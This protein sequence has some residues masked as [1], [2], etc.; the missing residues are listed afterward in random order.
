M[1]DC[2]EQTEIFFIEN[3]QFKFPSGTVPVVGLP[4]K[5][6]YWAKHEDILRADERS[7]G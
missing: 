3:K 2:I 1:T 5:R 7:S 4:G 6:G